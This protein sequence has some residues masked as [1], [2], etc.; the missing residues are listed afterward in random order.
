MLSAG[1]VFCTPSVHADQI[2]HVPEPLNFDLVRGLD[3]KAGELEINSL[4][5]ARLSGTHALAWS[6]EVE[7]A[8]ASG[9]GVEVELP[10]SGGTIAGTKLSMQGRVAGSTQVAHGWQASFEHLWK[11]RRSLHVLYLLA[12]A[13]SPSIST[14]WMLGPRGSVRSAGSLDAEFIANASIFV[15]IHKGLT[16]GLEESYARS[17]S[18][19][20]IELLP[21]AHM[22]FG[23][24]AALQV[25]MGFEST[26]R[27]LVPVVALR[28]IY[29][30]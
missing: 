14:L 9:F 18:R 8:P 10:I 22:D 16:L 23:T 30:R 17:W 2:P 3:A 27:G 29:Q 25:G 6:P 1:A 21:Q 20:S 24:H 12:V 19:T 5:S 15:R 26:S 13:V 11:G 28:M 4:F 7:W